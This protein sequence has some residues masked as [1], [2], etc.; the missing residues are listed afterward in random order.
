MAQSRRL[1]E[2][3]LTG[4]PTPGDVASTSVNGLPAWAQAGGKP[5]DPT[6]ANPFALNNP[7]DNAQGWQGGH[8]WQDFL[9]DDGNWIFRS[10]ADDSRATNDGDAAQ[11]GE[12]VSY[13]DPGQYFQQMGYTP[14]EAR[15]GGQSY[16]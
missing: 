15:Q 7:E 2:D 13:G 14:M 9:P 1:V 6:A 16:R 12:Q 3:A 5:F 8:G 11:Y 10:P 4:R